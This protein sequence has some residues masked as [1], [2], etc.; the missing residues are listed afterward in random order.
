MLNWFTLRG[1]DVSQTSLVTYRF[2]RLKRDSLTHKGSNIHYLWN[3]PKVRTVFYLIKISLSQP[4]SDQ[5]DLAV[6]LASKSKRVHTTTDSEDSEDEY[7]PCQEVE[8]QDTDC[9]YSTIFF[10]I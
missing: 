5:N 7:A 4:V 1:H 8:I 3:L 2:L 9:K 10:L 6:F